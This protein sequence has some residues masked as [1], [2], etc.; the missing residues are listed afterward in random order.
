M[1]T[2]LNAIPSEILKECFLTGTPC[3]KKLEPMKPQRSGLYFAFH[4]NFGHA[5][6]AC[7]HLKDKIE[8]L[9]RLGEL[10]KFI[11]ANQAPDPAEFSC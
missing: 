4:K 8:R 9:I 7:R 11:K 3:F 5:T 2:E 1:Y 10:V 6:N